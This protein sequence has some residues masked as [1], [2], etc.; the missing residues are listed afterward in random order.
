MLIK[1]LLHLFL[2]RICKVCAVVAVALVLPVLAHAGT[3]NGK[4][5]DG[6]NYGHQFGRGDVPVVPEANAGIVLIRFFSAALLFSSLQLWRTKRG[7][8]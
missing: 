3:D 2:N 7:Q 1:R 6:Q 4:G 5:N 8:A